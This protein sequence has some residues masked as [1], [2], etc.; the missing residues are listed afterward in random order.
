MPKSKLESDFQAS[1]IKEIKR[2]FPGSWVL[3]NDPNYL[4]GVPDL[5]V[6]WKRHWAALEVKRSID[7]DYEP[8]QEWYI[9]EFNKMSFSAMICPE[10]REDVLHAL[11][12]AF[13]TER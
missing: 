10:N 7:E 11:Q 3:K 6:L 4:Q 5:M 9:S 13:R 12:L 2:M 1:L 8:N